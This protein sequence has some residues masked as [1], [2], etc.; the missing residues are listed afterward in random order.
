MRLWIK[1]NGWRL[2]L[3]AALLPVWLLLVIDMWV[4]ALGIWG[5]C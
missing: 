5:G 1:S 3:A 2:L 4:L